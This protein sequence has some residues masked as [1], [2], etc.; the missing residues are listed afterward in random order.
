MT[1]LITCDTE[2]DWREARRQGLGASDAPVVMGLSPWRSPLQ[3][4]AEK[5]GLNEVAP[6]ETERMR[7]GRRLEPLII[8]VYAEVTRRTA[9]RSNPLLIHRSDQQPFM[10]ATLDGWVSASDRLSP[11][12]LEVKT[13][14]LFRAED[15][16]EAPPLMYQVQVQHALAV[17]KAQ[18]GSV[19]VLIGG[20]RLLWADV[21]RNQ[22]FID[23][24]IEKEAAFWNRLQAKEPPRPDDSA[25]TAK[26]LR[27]LYPREQTGLVVTL[28]PEANEWDVALIRAKADKAEAEKRERLYKNLLQAAIGEAEAGALPDGTLY[29][30]KARDVKGFTV[31]A[32]V[33]RVLTRKAGPP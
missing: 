28:P 13:T 3:L 32:R 15:W 14:G 19:V 9:E 11:G 30:W 29:Q 27:R 31:E 5:L 21:E 10:Q 1:T 2:K 17:V 25:E 16:A 23:V 8:D 18:W 24:L 4:Y 33:D 12:V 20:Q 7:W 6:E 22:P 26:L